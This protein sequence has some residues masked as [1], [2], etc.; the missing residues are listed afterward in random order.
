M[1]LADLTIDTNVF[2]HSCNPIEQRFGHAVAL[3][4]RLLSCSAM[5]CVDD[6]F[7]TNTAANRSLIGGEY[8]QKLV[9]GT[10][11]AQVLAHLALHG[12]I[13]Q[14][15]RSTNVATSRKVNQLIANHRDRTFVR[16]ALNSVDKVFVS[17]DHKDFSARKRRDLGQGLGIVINEADA[18][19]ALL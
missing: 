12:R 2:L 4:Q 15:S 5:L 13:S 8:L 3:M 17:H 11:P 1:P 9:P 16:V 19:V 6:G 10:L 14:L 7:S 18:C